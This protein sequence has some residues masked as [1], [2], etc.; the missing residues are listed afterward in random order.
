MQSP[1]ARLAE[2]N[3]I[4]AAYQSRPSSGWG[5]Q[6]WVRLFRRLDPAFVN[7]VHLEVREIE[8]EAGRS[9]IVNSV[10]LFVSQALHDYAAA[11]GDKA[12][13]LDRQ[14][15]RWDALKRD[16]ATHGI[17][18]CTHELC[19]VQAELHGWRQFFRERLWFLPSG[20]EYD[21]QQRQTRMQPDRAWQWYV[22]SVF[23]DW[24]TEAPTQ[25][26][27]D[28]VEIYLDDLQ[29]LQLSLP[30]LQ[31]WLHFEPLTAPADQAAAPS[32]D[33]CA[34]PCAEPLACCDRCVD[35]RVC[36]A[37]WL[38]TAWSAQHDEERVYSS[39]RPLHCPFCRKALGRGR[40]PSA[41]APTQRRRKAKY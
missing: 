39:W 32:C 36:R 3:G 19:A 18:R 29:E 26:L 11:L 13:E 27:G 16:A 8:P 38:K 15:D 5:E 31:F 10:H 35:K 40:L 25:S 33:L 24:Y 6:D 12:L 34:E 7:S 4:V 17:E 9:A 22:C 20:D 1:L 14:R 28:T 37:C 30:T 41:K 23:E 21:A 2:F